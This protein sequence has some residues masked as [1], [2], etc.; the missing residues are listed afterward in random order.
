MYWS[1]LVIVNVWQGKEDK[2]TKNI[3]KDAKKY[4][5]I[6][7]TQQHINDKINIATI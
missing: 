2:K 4:T 1:R 3:Q 5:D 7:V 6:S